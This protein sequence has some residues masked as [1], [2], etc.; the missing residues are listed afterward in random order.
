L[1]TIAANYLD[2]G[3]PDEGI[4]LLDRTFKVDAACAR[5][6]AEIPRFARHRSVAAFDALLAKFH[7]R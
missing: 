2:A 3:Y 5:R 1:I 6:V 4:S 7:V